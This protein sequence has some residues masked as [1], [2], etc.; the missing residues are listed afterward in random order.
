MKLASLFSPPSSSFPGPR[1]A[2]RGGGRGPPGRG[3]PAPP[4]SART[5]ATAPSRA[6]LTPGTGSTWHGGSHSEGKENSSRP[7][8]LETRSYFSSNSS[9]HSHFLRRSRSQAR[10]TAKEKLKREA[11]A[12]LEKIDGWML[13]LLWE[14]KQRWIVSFPHFSLSLSLSSLS[15]V[16]VELSRVE[17]SS[18]FVRPFPSF[19][20]RSWGLVQQQVAKQSP[21]CYVG[22]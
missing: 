4:A 13:P 12:Y 5:R 3:R 10:H 21:R 22:T 17:P 9:I 14:L 11:R 1:S 8:R 6:T 16:G 18:S 2:L 20:L 19:L 15:K 7:V